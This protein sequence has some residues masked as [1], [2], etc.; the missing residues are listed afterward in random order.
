VKRQVTVSGTFRAATVMIISTYRQCVGRREL[1]CRQRGRK[2]SRR[3]DGW[4]VVAG[5]REC[6]RKT[7]GCESHGRRVGI[8]NSD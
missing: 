1:R 5:G 6:E 7:R 2:E 4:L 8:S 3:V